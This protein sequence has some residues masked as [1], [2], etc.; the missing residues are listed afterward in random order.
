MKGLALLIAP[1]GKGKGM[2]A[3]EAPEPE[4]AA[5]F[6]AA[7]ADAYE[8]LRDEDLDGFKLAL[9]QAIETCHGDDEE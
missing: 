1:K 2:G 7:A 5:N 8:A 9:R 4:P 6:D 3:D